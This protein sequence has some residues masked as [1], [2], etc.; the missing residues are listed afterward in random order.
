MSVAIGHPQAQ[1][2]TAK[3]EKDVGQGSRSSG[4]S[5]LNR[6]RPFIW[7]KCLET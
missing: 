5:L 7:A 4:V 6:S 1:A 2:S 3:T